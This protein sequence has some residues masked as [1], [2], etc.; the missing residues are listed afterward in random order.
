[1]ALA[2][3]A[4]LTVACNGDDELTNVVTKEPHAISFTGSI[5]EEGEQVSRAESEGLEN[6]SDKF[7]VFGYKNGNKETVMNGYTVNWVETSAGSTSTNTH[8]WEYVGQGGASKSQ[9]IKYW[10]EKAD[11]Y[12]FFGYVPSR[13]SDHNSPEYYNVIVTAPTTSSPNIHQITFSDLYYCAEYEGMLMYATS[14]ESDGVTPITKMLDKSTIP[15]ISKMKRIVPNSTGTTKYSGPV[16]L[17]FIPPY[18]KVKIAFERISTVE[19]SPISS[20]SFRPST[21]SIVSKADVIC[22]Y[23][24][25]NGTTAIS[26]ANTT[27]TSPVFQ[28]GMRFDTMSK[29]EGVGSS[30]QVKGIMDDEEKIY[31]AKP[32]YMLFP[33]TGAPVN[34]VLQA[35]IGSGLQE[36]IVPAAYM[37]WEMGYE[38]TYVFK[39][40][41]AGLNLINVIKVGIKSWESIG[42]HETSFH[43]W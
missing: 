41:K 40:T 25:T 14:F 11:N 34:F 17:E 3:T 23:N 7:V 27:T 33:T 37:K 2:A 22:S 15:L 39:I 16:E 30:A 18:A 20:I 26:L 38:Y 4:L 10:D 24:I 12:T 9:V 43:N 32:Q 5:S 28:N 1:M 19:N 13:I 35:N 29:T 6:Y 36:C 31:F 21:G 42:T 8:D